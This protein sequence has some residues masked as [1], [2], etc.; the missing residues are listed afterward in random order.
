VTR[1]GEIVPRKFLLLEALQLSIFV[2]SDLTSARDLAI[3]RI[4]ASKEFRAE[5]TREIRKTFRRHSKLGTVKV[6]LS[7]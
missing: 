3:R 5:L 6:T 4:L 7:L 1:K 2:P